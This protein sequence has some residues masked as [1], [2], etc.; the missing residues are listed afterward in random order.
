MSGNEF[1]S[2]IKEHVS[3]SRSANTHPAKLL[4][5]S[6]LL[7]ALFNVGLEELIPGIETKLGSK[8][9]GLRGS[10]DL[11]FSNVIFEIKVDLEKELNDAEN[12]LMKY[13]QVL[14][15]MEPERQHVGIATDVIEFV[16]YT[17]KLK[18]GKV[19][20]LNRISKI[21]IADVSSY[22]SIL[23]LDSFVFSKPKIKPSSID[24]RWRFGPES[25]TFN[26]TIERLSSLWGEIKDEKDVTLKLDLWTKNMEIVY[27]D[28]PEVSAFIDQTYLVTLVKLIVYLRLSGD[29]VIREERI[30]RA[31]TGEY[32][33]AYGITNLIEEDFFTW[34]LH[35]KICDRALRV[36]GD[37]ARELLRYDLS[38]IDEDFFKEIYQEIVK[39]SDRHRIGEY[40]TPEWL[41]ELIL[42][43]SLE[44]WNN[45]YERLPRILDPACGSG[46]FLC[47]AIHIIKEHPLSKGQTPQD[48]LNFVLDNIIGVDINPLA[49]II[50]RAN[51]LMALGELLQL[52]KRVMIPIY[53]ADSVRTPHVVETLAAE[54]TVSV[55]EFRV[56]AADSKKEY[57]IQIPKNIASQKTIFDQVIAGFKAA[58]NTYRIRKNRKEATEVFERSC[59]IQLSV[60]EKAVLKN[61]LDNILSLID[62]GLDSIWMFM[63]SNIYA[64][65]ALSQSKFD[66]IV[67][68]P[69]WIAMRY[70]GNKNYQDFLKEKTLS[71]GL[72][73]SSQTHLFTHMEMATIFF[74]NAI[75]MYL[76][77]KGLIAFVMPRSVLTGALHHAKFKDFKRPASRLIKI[78]DL[79]NVSPL[80][81]VPSCALIAVKGENTS[82]PVP[83][84]KYSGKLD[85][86]NLHLSDAIKQLS[87]SE[88]LYNPPSIPLKRSWYYDKVKEGATLVPRSFWF[89]DFVVHETLGFDASTPLVKTSE[90]ILSGAKEPWRG[91]EIRGN[92]EADFIYATIL[93]GDILP[94]GF[95]KLRPLVLPIEPTS[96]GY[97]LLDVNNLRSR[98]FVHMA[99]WLEKCQKLWEKK[100][101]SKSLNDYPRIVS[102]INYNNKL[103]NQNPTKRFIILYNASGTNIASCVVDRENLPPFVISQT[104]VKPYGFVVDSK[105]FYY[106]TNDE[107]EAHFICSIL[108]S[109]VLNEAIKPLQP[110]GLFGE[111]EIQRRPFMFPI[112]KFDKNNPKHAKLAQISKQCHNKLKAVQ[113]SKKSTAGLRKDARAMLT[114]KIK[115]INTLVQ[116]LLRS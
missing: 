101:T 62:A 50:A 40:Y 111:R 11:I 89:I 81:N 79:E 8:L 71:F 27:G 95:S 69:P 90:D 52:G 32:F 58:V 93:G 85:E 43:E 6:S 91:I 35:P 112:P 99:D 70:I 24:L 19:I 114:K 16:A 56:K 28:K 104:T 55:Y 65:I 13:F 46:T 94:F 74:C 39:R 23:W 78:Y 92:V 72:L 107:N 12:K 49:V 64:P 75:D 67:G 82:Y 37:V 20:G 86:K 17:P 61:T 97:R 45:M 25:P 80:F 5:L 116:E 57:A 29:N 30:L 109:N 38:L 36:I 87:V 73:N 76:H 106:E 113:F 10:A 1:S 4:V 96:S 21:N 26:V 60:N 47:N 2:I 41:V 15:E 68:N 115:K 33:S 31:L 34:I 103:T 9:Y 84:K 53:V 83:A 22:E 14:Y 59:R 3:K 18:D 98:G 54:G 51:Y 77:D 110:R 42:K 63:L 105:S 102:W 44:I 88:Y 7:K 108:N 66:M 48:V 100:A